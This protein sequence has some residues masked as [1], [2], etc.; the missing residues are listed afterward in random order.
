MIISNARYSSHRL[1][2]LLSITDR[3]CS[4]IVEPARQLTALHR[5][6]MARQ[7]ITKV[8]G[9]DVTRQEFDSVTNGDILDELLLKWKS[10]EELNA[11]V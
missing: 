8:T 11:K 9:G 10:R 2:Y 4:F 3:P 5:A 6:T 7:G 1:R